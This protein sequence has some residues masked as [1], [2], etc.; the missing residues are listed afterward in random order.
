MFFQA[1]AFVNLSPF[2]VAQGLTIFLREKTGL[3]QSLE[4]HCKEVFFHIKKS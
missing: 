4:S 1:R 3:C 2:R